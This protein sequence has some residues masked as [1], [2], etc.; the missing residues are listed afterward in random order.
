LLI[1][2]FYKG[3]IDFLLFLGIKSWGTL[4][5]IA[6]AYR[7]ATRRIQ[8]VIVIAG[9]LGKTTTTRA[10]MAV[11]HGVAPRYLH[12]GQNC[13]GFVGLNL[14][15]QGPFSP[16]AIVEVGIGTPGQ[17][18]PYASVLRPDI[19]IMTAIASDHLTRFKDFEQLWNEK[20]A[21][22]RSLGPHELAILN[23]DDAEV[24]KMASQTQARVITFGL[25]ESCDVAARIIE[26]N[27]N[28]TRFNLRIQ[29]D[30]VMVHSRLIGREAVRALVAA[31][32]VG[33]AE[34]VGIDKIH[35]RLEWLT[36]TPGRMQPIPLIN[37]AV[38]IV[39][40]FKAGI[41]TIY[42]AINSFA[43]IKSCRRIIVL[44][45][46]Y[47]PLEPITQSYADVARYAAGVADR[48]ILIGPNSQ[49]Y[50][51][52]L[53]D[54]NLKTFV[55]DLP[56]VEAVAKSL[57]NELRSGDVVLIKGRGEEKLERI[58]LELSGRKVRCQI[59]FCELENILCQECPC[60]GIPAR[61]SMEKDLSP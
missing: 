22:V 57:K 44:G 14:M 29:Q 45:S 48:I 61:T 2:K 23:G 26:C 18:A 59:P 55:E 54:L 56:T 6:T 28:G 11:M 19:V 40:S 52:G 20:V 35:Q 24:M 60:L 53:K 7:C 30:S 38:A 5:W 12:A 46:I 43:E 13:F 49:Y 25:S 16:H 36:P 17:M 51:S 47:Q 50:L 27:P 31:A 3:W 32:T 58:A 9:S 39:D 15:R 41:E 4:D 1:Q 34:G 21:I 37:G 42:A 33:W 8:R 10:T